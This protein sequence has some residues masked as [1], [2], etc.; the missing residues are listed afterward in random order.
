MR[1]LDFLLPS[2]C[3]RLAGSGDQG[4]MTSRIDRSNNFDLLRLAFASA[5]F[6]WHSYALTR[7][8]ALQVF[9]A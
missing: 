3:R 1:R 9:G 8:P 4:S 6:L 7:E 2:A 5:V